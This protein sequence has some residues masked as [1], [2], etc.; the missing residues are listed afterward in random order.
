[1]RGNRD[2]E[3]KYCWL[4]AYTILLIGGSGRCEEKYFIFHSGIHSTLVHPKKGGAGGQTMKYG[5]ICF[6]Y[7]FDKGQA[8][9]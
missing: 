2:R 6:S 7:T 9:I 4:R 5:F 3:N 1:M 8:I